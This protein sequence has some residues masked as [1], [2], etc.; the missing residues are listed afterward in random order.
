MNPLLDWLRQATP[1]QRE[2]AAALAGTSENYLYQ[3]AAGR[4]EPGVGLAVRLAD[5]IREVGSG[6]PEVTVRDLALLRAV[7]GL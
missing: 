6:L 7:E 3:L 4:R 1:A 5:A 2:R